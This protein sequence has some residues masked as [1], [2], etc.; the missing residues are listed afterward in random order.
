[1]KIL[2][3][4]AR[5]DQII[6]RVQ[7]GQVTDFKYKYKFFADS[8]E[9]LI[10]IIESYSKSSQLVSLAQ[11]TGFV[12]LF[13]YHR[14]TDEGETYITFGID[15]TGKYC[16]IFP[17]EKAKPISETVGCHLSSI[18]EYL[19]VN[20]GREDVEAILKDKIPETLDSYFTQLEK[21]LEGKK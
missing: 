17:G 14:P 3:G 21:H 20:D 4:S 7:L 6:E 8:N 9:Y 15:S 19:I 16:E 12:P 11:K 10:S 1:M 2:V 5:L 18:M 13:D